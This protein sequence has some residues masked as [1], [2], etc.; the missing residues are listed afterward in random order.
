MTDPHDDEPQIL[1]LT[2]GE[3]RLLQTV[4][5]ADGNRNDIYL[6]HRRPSDD[7]TTGAGEPI[8]FVAIIRSTDE[9]PSDTSPSWAWQRGPTERSICIAV[10]E[11]IVNVPP[12]PGN[13]V[14]LHPDVQWFADRIRQDAGPAVAAT[15]A[16]AKLAQTYA[17][18]CSEV[19][20]ATNAC[21]EAANQA[22]GAR[23]MANQ[24]P[25]HEISIRNFTE[26]AEQVEGKFIPLYRT[27]VEA[28]TKARDAAKSL[29]SA[30]MDHDPEIA[31]MLSVQSDVL[32][33]VA[34][35]KAIL[36]ANF[37]S[38]PAGFVEGIEETNTIM[39]DPFPEPG[40]IYAPP[41]PTERVCPWCAE[42]IKAAAVICR[43]CG[44]DVQEHPSTDTTS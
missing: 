26:M 12:P 25:Q 16:A 34:T 4:H 31:L 5:R 14:S 29:L 44:R 35:A 28:C 33:E 32:D 6:I 39:K 10:A 1:P 41:P 37:G 11:A 2:E 21:L 38:T 15:E 18:A 8:N 36:T 40:N 13:S 23:N 24:R 9:D 17:A 7:Q 22:V 20:S 27:F 42:T 19:L 3:E 30:Q 43:F